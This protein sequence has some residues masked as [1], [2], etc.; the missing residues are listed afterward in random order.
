MIGVRVVL[1]F[2]MQP[3]Q[4]GRRHLLGFP[5]AEFGEHMPFQHIAVERGCRA[6]ALGFGVLGVSGQPN[7][8]G[9]RQPYV[10]VAASPR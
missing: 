7:A 9:C 1:H 2:A 3:G 10:S 4:L 8:R 6:L 5:I